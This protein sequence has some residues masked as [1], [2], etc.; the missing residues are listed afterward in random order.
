MATNE[1]VLETLTEKIQQQARLIAGLQAEL[2]RARQASLESMLGP[3]RM[4][5]AVLLYVGK[6]ADHIA[7]HFAQEFGSD[8]TGAVLR[9][10]FL[11]DNAPM[12]PEQREAF[13]KAMNH[14]MTRW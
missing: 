1:I 14:G 7:Q 3:L 13:R 11:L 6:D 10:L 2:Q 8:I 9:H 5:E 12:Q 4:R